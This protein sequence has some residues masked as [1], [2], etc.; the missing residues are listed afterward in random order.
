MAKKKRS[1]TTETAK[2]STPKPPEEQYASWWQNNLSRREMTKKILV[3]STIGATVVFVMLNQDNDEYEYEDEE[4]YGGIADHDALELQ[5]TSGWNVGSSSALALMDTAPN[6]SKGGQNWKDLLQPAALLAAYK[7]ASETLLPYVVP[8][9]VQSLGESTLCSAMQP[10]FSPA[11]QNAYSCGLGMRDLLK[12]S[13]NPESTMIVVDVPGPQSV[14][15]AAAMSDVAEPLINFDNWPHPLGR[16]KSHETLGALLYYGAEVQENR[17]KRPAAKAPVVVVLDDER[18]AALEQGD[19]TTFDNRYVA[20]MPTVQNLK[21]MGI[22]HVLYVASPSH[23]VHESDDLN[24]DFVAYNDAG[25]DVSMLPLSSFTSGGSAAIN[26]TATRTAASAATPYYY[27][28]QPHGHAFFFYYGGMYRPV[29]SVPSSYAPPSS[30]RRPSYTAARRPTVFT[31]RS[32]GAMAT[33]IGKQ[34]PT[35]FGRVSTAVGSD[36]TTRV[37]RTGSF[38]SSRSGSFGRSGG[39]GFSS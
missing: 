14:A 29:R 20:K 30:V 26:T 36:G 12:K 22:S 5:R 4:S 18:I 35:G 31:S 16:V 37:G 34:R 10:V 7:P 1:T 15:F 38:G 23:E 39:R 17:S 13:N 11:M 24:E 19:A 33:G 2:A 6:D 8:T 3:G 28:G 25:I 27:G 21:N 9:L 32:V